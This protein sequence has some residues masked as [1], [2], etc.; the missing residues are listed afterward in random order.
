MVLFLA[1]NTYAYCVCQSNDLCQINVVKRGAVIFQISV[2]VRDVNDNV[3]QFD[4]PSKLYVAE[5]SARGT[6]VAT[7]RARDAD[8]GVN[9]DVRFTLTSSASGAFLLDELTGA[10]TV[11]VPLDRE[12]RDEYELT[13]TLTDRGL[14]PLSSRRALTVY[15]TDENDHSP[16]FARESFS[17]RVA[18]DQPI[19]SRLLS[20]S[21][22]DS[23]VGI[24]A[25]LRYSLR[26]G[27]EYQY[28]HLDRLTGELS[29]WQ[30]LDHELFSS[31]QLVLEAVDLGSPQRT[32][33][34]QLTVDVTDVN[35]YTPTFLNQPIVVSVRENVAL[36]PLTLTTVQARD[37]DTGV[38]GRVSYSLIGGDR[39]VFNIS[40]ND[41]QISLVR[42]LDREETSLYEL[43]VQAANSGKSSFNHLVIL[44]EH[45]R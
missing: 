41:G 35:D 6:V 24:N 1:I 15:V 26:S 11:N 39:S 27:N 36:L 37:D 20:F 22:T 29:V 16:A 10:L 31:Y 14:P 4:M 12:S 3:P 33:T 19:G 9:S 8:D 18:E 34:A 5:N 40:R 43:V 30:R 23:D 13:V 28:F 17:I 38:A 44:Q 25:E 21:A 45:R 2:T 32:A 7:L 42:A